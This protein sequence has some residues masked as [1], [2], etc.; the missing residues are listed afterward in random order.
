M[1]GPAPANSY[2]TGNFAPVRSEDD[3]ELEVVGEFPSDLRGAIYRNGPNP[4]FEPRGHYHWFTGDGMI[5]ASSSTTVRSLIA[6]AM[7]ARRNGNSNM[8]PGEHCSEVLI[9]GLLIPR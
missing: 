6:I 2:L 7:S 5:H 4:Q 3:F 1:D 8:R 9:Q